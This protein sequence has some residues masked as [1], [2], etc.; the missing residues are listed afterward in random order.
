MRL[1]T[2]AQPLVHAVMLHRYR[3]PEH[4]L[5]HTDNAHK[6]KPVRAGQMYAF[7]GTILT[8]ASCAWDSPG[9]TPGKFCRAFL[10]GER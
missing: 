1:E 8:N 10:D 6:F 4:L 5:F 7:I 9:F 2:S 3:L